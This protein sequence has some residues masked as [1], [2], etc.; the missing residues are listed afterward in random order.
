MTV[1]LTIW[2]CWGR[3]GGG[4]GSVRRLRIGGPREKGRGV[5]FYAAV[6]GT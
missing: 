2:V 5:R 3:R 6:S 4:A 1:E